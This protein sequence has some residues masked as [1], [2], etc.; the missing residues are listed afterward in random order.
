[1]RLVD[2]RSR[3]GEPMP[4]HGIPL[5]WEVGGEI[6]ARLAIQR[7]GQRLIVRDL[8]GAI[9]PLLDAVAGVATDA[10]AVVDGDGRVLREV[11]PR[12]ASPDSTRPLTLAELDAAVRSAWSRETAEDSEL[13]SEDNPAAEHC[14]VTALVVRELLGGDILVAG[15]VL[16]GLRVHRHAWNRLPSG[17][18]LDL[19]REQFRRG[20]AFEEPVV[21]EPDVAWRHA[22]RF[23]LFRRRV[24]DALGVLET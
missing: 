15:V 17:I 8:E 5:G 3:P 11:A 21:G 2:L 24:L 20:E 7:D 23:A 18:A 9:E 12:P 16:D 10:T 13:W 19:T 4:G 22:E 6:V 14:G 1:M